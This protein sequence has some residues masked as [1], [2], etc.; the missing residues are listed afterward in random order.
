VKRGSVEQNKYIHKITK[1]NI[2]IHGNVQNKNKREGKELKIATI[3]SRK[4]VYINSRNKRLKLKE[5]KIPKKI[6]PK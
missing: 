3:K 4:W 6:K 5:S 1:I 2:T